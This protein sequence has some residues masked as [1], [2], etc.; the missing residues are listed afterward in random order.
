MLSWS[1]SSTLLSP[2]DLVFFSLGIFRFFV[3]RSMAPPPASSSTLRSVVGVSEPSFL[4]L[5]RRL[6]GEGSVSEFIQYP[7]SD[8]VALASPPSLSTT[9]GGHTASDD[10][11]DN[12]VVVR[13]LKV[14]FSGAIPAVAM[15]SKVEK[16]SARL[17][18]ETVPLPQ[19]GRD[20]TVMCGMNA[21]TGLA[22]QRLKNGTRQA[23][24]REVDQGLV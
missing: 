9:P 19:P 18:L 11:E 15:E 4:G 8:F 14:L 21:A 22:T 5:P 13:P 17:G 10:N 12:V 1:E 3:V 20:G 7:P 2:L 23:C 24:H 6:D 16:E